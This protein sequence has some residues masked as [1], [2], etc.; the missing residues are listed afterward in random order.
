MTPQLAVNFVR[1]R[2]SDFQSKKKACDLQEITRELV[3]ETINRG[4]V[5]NV[6][7]IIL[8]FNG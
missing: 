7:I 4:S 6:S 5:D 1:K 2:L 3:L 8:T